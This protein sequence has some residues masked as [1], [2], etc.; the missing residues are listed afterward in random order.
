MSSPVVGVGLINAIL[1]GVYGHTLRLLADENDNYAMGDD[2]AA[3]VSHI[4]VAGSVA[5][6]V[7]TI[8]ASPLELGKIQAQNQLNTA[9]GAAFR[10]PLACLQDIYRARGLAGCMRGFTATIL[11]ETPSYGAYFAAY[12]VLCRAMTPEGASVRDLGW[13]KLLLAGGMA[14]MAGWLSTYPIDVVKTRMQSAEGLVYK[15]TFECAK[16][17]VRHEPAAMWRGLTATLVRAFP[18][19]AATL[20]TYTIAMR[21]F[22]DLHASNS[23]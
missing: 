15:N 7:N 8:I 17:L 19:N 6:L 12:A 3:P 10:G 20:F 1:F 13:G 4:F 11:R 18:T 16:H 22:S 9:E 5:G 14:G 23:D 2:S 21:M